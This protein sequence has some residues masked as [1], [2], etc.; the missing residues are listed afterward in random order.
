[1]HAETL[2]HMDKRVKA[3]EN[4]S[5]RL[6]ALSF[7]SYKYAM[8]RNPRQLRVLSNLACFSLHKSMRDCRN[9]RCIY[10]QLHDIH[11]AQSKLLRV[12]IT[13]AM[14]GPFVFAAYGYRI[15]WDSR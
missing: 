8:R 14:P 10:K 9:C 12:R 3:G 13:S 1:M 15:N 11:V 2:K 5:L 4:Q 6:H 7:R